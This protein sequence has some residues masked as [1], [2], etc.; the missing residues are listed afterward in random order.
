MEFKPSRFLSNNSTSESKA[1]ANLIILNQ[2]LVSFEIFK[3]I[4]SHTT[5]RICADG[6]ANRLY[7]TFQG[8]SLDMKQNYVREKFMF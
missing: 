5:C 2:P 7:D 8:S 3:K 4:W 1:T 6:G